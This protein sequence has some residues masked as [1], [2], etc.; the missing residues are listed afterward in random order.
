L[1]ESKTGG[2]HRTI[3]NITLSNDVAVSVSPDE[4]AVLQFHDFRE[5]CF[6]GP[7]YGI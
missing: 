1:K 7:S 4:T 5:Q 6:N 2:Q 3:I